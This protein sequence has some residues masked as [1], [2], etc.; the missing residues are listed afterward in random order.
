[1][2]KSGQVLTTDQEA[3]ILVDLD[4]VNG[5]H[6]RVEVRLIRGDRDGAQV[7]ARLEGMTPLQMAHIDALQDGETGRYYRVMA[8]TGTSMLTSNPIFVTHTDRQTGQ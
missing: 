4:K 3:R 5:V 2:A 1:M 8:R 6:E 7:V